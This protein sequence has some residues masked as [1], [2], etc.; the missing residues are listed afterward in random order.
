MGDFKY[1]LTGEIGYI[2]TPLK[3]NAIWLAAKCSTK[4][5]LPEMAGS[6]LSTSALQSSPWFSCSHSSET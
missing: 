1:D 5:L 3:N 2:N 4:I 6:I